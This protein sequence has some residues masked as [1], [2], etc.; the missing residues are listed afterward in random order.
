MLSFTCDSWLKDFKKLFFKINR[1][2]I[3]LNFLSSPADAI[4]KKFFKID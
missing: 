2:S 1:K 4:R 3:T